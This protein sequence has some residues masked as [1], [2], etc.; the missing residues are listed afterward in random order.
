[1]RQFFSTINLLFLSAVSKQLKKARMVLST[2]RTLLIII[3]FSVLVLWFFL[4]TKTKKNTFSPRRNMFC[5]Q[6][7][8]CFATLVHRN[9]C[10]LYSELN[11]RKKNGQ[12]ISKA[13]AQSVEVSHKWNIR[14][15]DL[16]KYTK[17]TYTYWGPDLGRVIY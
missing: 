6:K 14:N 15:F 11:S 8:L 3:F 2:R 16:N 7:M 12:T 13:H 5:R 17:R 9:L 1:M 4:V 10:E